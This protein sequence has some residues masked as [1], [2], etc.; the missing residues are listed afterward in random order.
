MQAEHNL[1]AARFRDFTAFDVRVERRLIFAGH[2]D[3]R[4][5]PKQLVAQK[6]PNFQADDALATIRLGSLRH[7]ALAAGRASQPWSNRLIDEAPVFL[8]S[9]VNADGHAAQAPLLPLRRFRRLIALAHGR[10][11]LHAARSA[12]HLHG[13]LRPRE[14]QFTDDVALV[15]PVFV[16]VN[17]L[18][19]GLF[20]ASP[21][22]EHVVR[23]NGVERVV[24][25]LRRFRQHEIR[26]FR[27]AFPR[28][29]LIIRSLRKRRRCFADAARRARR[30]QCN[31]RFAARARVCKGDIPFKAPVRAVQHHPA[32]FGRRCVFEDDE[33]V[34]RARIKGI[35]QRVF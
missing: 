22:E 19:D 1:R 15:M 13:E 3:V 30:G 27:V 26:H 7:A 12:F 9:R 11:L 18:G 21:V 35:M 10:F 31:A 28:R 16:R 25:A 24:E 8:M 33:R 4:A 5:L 6:H 29:L 23:A 14:G 32:F 17:R 2:D 20:L 34:L